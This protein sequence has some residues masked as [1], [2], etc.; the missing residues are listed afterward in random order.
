MLSRYLFLHYLKTF[1]LVFLVILGILY[2]YLIGE[3]FLAFKEK[4]WRI[5]PSY[6]INLMLT[7]FFYISSFVAGLALL[8]TFRRLIQRKIDLLSQSFSISP[9]RFSTAILLFSFLLFLLNLL[10][11]YSLY[12]DVQKNLYKIEKGY[13]KAKELEKGVVRNLWLIEEKNGMKAFYYF[14][15]VEVSTGMVHGFYRLKTVEGSI[16]ELITASQGEWKGESILLK[17][18]R[19]KE[20]VR[21]EESTKTITLSYINLSHIKSLAERPEH[22]S[23]KDLLSLSLLGKDIGLNQRYYLYEITKRLLTS[24]LSLFL[25]ISVAWTYLRWRNFGVAFLSLIALFF[26]HWFLLALMLSLVENTSLSFT[27]LLLIYTPIPLFSLKGLYNLGKG[28]RV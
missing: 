8:I 26:S 19:I 15:L 17:E 24:I 9:L 16:R 13:K 11:S 10:G 20:L 1:L 25:S 6:S 3:V 27:L 2:I 12:P 22:L 5:L 18:A 21:G 7:V 14:D 4:D 23:M 28:F